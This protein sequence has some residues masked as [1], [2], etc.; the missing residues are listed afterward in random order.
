MSYFRIQESNPRAIDEQFADKYPA[1]NLIPTSN[2]G[3]FWGDGDLRSK[4]IDYDEVQFAV[5]SKVR[6]TNKRKHN[7][8]TPAEW[9]KAM[10]QLSIRNRHSIR[11]FLTYNN[12]TDSFTIGIPEKDA[13]QLEGWGVA[14]NCAEQLILKTKKEEFKLVLIQD[15]DWD[16]IVYPQILKLKNESS[17]RE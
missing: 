15:F 8:A 4:T 1:L 2:S 5:E 16:T 13:R 10:P 7:R 6:F 9:S 11:L 12:V 17:T 14:L 3:A